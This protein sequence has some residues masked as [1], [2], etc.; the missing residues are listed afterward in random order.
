MET[1][2]IDRSWVQVTPGTRY[3]QTLKLTFIVAHRSDRNYLT[4][5][6]AAAECWREH[7]NEIALR[8][9]AQRETAAHDALMAQHPDLHDREWAWSQWRNA[10][11][12]ELC[13][14]YRYLRALEKS[15]ELH[16]GR[17]CELAGKAQAENERLGVR[18][19]NLVSID[20][21]IKTA[22]HNCDGAE[23]A[24]ALQCADAAK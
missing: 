12:S 13:D 23:W 5:D 4:C 6:A 24:S 17:F 11:Y 21:A 2:T 14:Q 20:T 1:Q 9:T 19:N 8:E 7:N 18:Y 15:A 10:Q 22:R 16:G 3:R